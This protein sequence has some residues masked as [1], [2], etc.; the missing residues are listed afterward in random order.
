MHYNYPN[1]VCEVIKDGIYSKW[2]PK[3]PLKHQCAFSWWCDRKTDNPVN[4]KSFE[5]AMDISKDILTN[6][7]YKPTISYALFYHAGTVKPT[8]SKKQT[9]VTRIGEHYFY[10]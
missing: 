8:W 5:I 6:S 7:F 4:G 2:N 9:F 10:K 3:L 1:T